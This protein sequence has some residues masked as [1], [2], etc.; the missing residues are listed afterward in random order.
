MNRRL[1]CLILFLVVFSLSTSAVFAFVY[2]QASHTVTQIIINVSDILR[3]NGVGSTTQLTPYGETANWQCVD[4]AGEGDGDSSC[5]FSSGAA[6]RDTYQVQNHP[7]KTGIISNV[8]VNVRVKQTGFGIGFARTVLITHGVEYSG[9][10]EVLGFSYSVRSTTYQQ[11]PFTGEDWTW[12]EID[13]LEIGVRLSSL[14]GSAR[15][16]QVWIIVNLA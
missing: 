10:L 16:T 11:N 9:N 12:D 3:P 2:Q 4:D 13:N 1:L 14:G 5:V 7:S 15:C 6:G 8:I